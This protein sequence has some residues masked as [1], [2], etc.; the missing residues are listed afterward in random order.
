MLSIVIITYNEEKKISKILKNLKEQSFQDFEIIIA[1]SNSTDNT[2]KEAL[3]WK[4][5]FSEFTFLNFGKTKGP[6]YGRNRG[7]DKAKYE[8]LYFFDADTE[9]KEDDF[10]EKSLTYIKKEKIDLGGFYINSYYKKNKLPFMLF[11]VGF[12]A[13]QFISPTACGAGMFSTKKTFERIGGFDE[14]VHLCEDCDFVRDGK[15]KGMKMRMAPFSIIFDD[16]R[17][18][19]DGFMRT[20]WFYLKANIYRFFSG[21]S[22][23]DKERKYRFGE[24]K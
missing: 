21:R 5:H 9:L 22:Y 8:Y 19:Q 20:G 12:W 24:Y 14:K 1:D 3:K 18:Q 4:E 10:L 17:L 11:N 7:A 2:R 13:T 15:K 23:K 6:A 16:R